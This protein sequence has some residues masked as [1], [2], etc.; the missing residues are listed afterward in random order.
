MPTLLEVVQAAQ[1]ELGLPV[2][3]AVAS[4]NDPDTKQMFGLVNRLGKIL[5]GDK[6]GGWRRLTKTQQYITESVDGI[7]VN[8]TADS[9]AVTMA[10]TSSLSEGMA[11]INEAFS[12]DTYILS[13]DSATQATFSQ[14]ASDTASNDTQFVQTQY[15]IPSD[16]L[17]QI[18]MTHWDRN[19]H[20]EVL[21]PST[22]QQ[23]E[24]L[25]SGIVTVGPRLFYRL[26][27][28][29]FQ[30]F[31]L[32][33]TGQS[34]IVFEY[35]SKSWVE[36]IDGTFAEKCLADTDEIMFP[37][38][39]FVL[40]LKAFYKQAK[41]LDYTGDYQLYQSELGKA[42]AHDQGAPVLNLNGPSVGQRFLNRQNIPD[43][44][45]GQ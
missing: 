10:D 6:D 12:S 34:R 15:A 13:I 27:G 45:Y 35:N 33:S 30:I 36:K 28:D 24:Y 18:N 39:M 4:A 19:N 38:N 42:K 2:T 11:V 5:A 25:K 7:T 14:L 21:G 37:E 44:G 26:L 23:W 40:G 16:F 43:S 9:A 41:G 31:P 8:S 17:G 20:W 22:P 3:N 1:Q 29:Y 32:P